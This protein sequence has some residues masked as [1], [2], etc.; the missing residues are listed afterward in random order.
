MQDIYYVY[1]YLREDGSPYYIGKGKDSRAWDN[2]HTVNL[3]PNDR[4]VILEENLSDKQSQEK[5]I[6]LISYF[7][8]KDIGTG[9]LRNRTNGGDGGDTSL[10]IDYESVG[11]KISKTKN[12]PEWKETVGD[13]TNKKI[14]KTKTIQQND[15]E[16]KETS[17]LLK[18]K[19]QS[20][21]LNDPEWID[22]IGKEKIEKY[23]ET[24]SNEQWKR[25]VGVERSRKTVENT[26]WEERNRKSK[27]TLNS[28]E[29][30]KNNCKVCEHCGNGPFRPSTFS[31]WHGDKCKM[32]TN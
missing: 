9:I 1:A 26:D 4:I 5:E 18:S 24:I 32:K 17:G 21:T 15:I 6:E 19:N 3:P 12:D 22:T 13:R 30:K 28:D 7:G 11:K 16:W 2:N 20:N 8:R 23:K 25:T 14:S 31:R 10:Y 27:E 29:W